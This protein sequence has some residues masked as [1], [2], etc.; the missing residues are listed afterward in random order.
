MVLS[1]SLQVL[2]VILRENFS[3]KFNISNATKLFDKMFHINYDTFIKKEP[4]YLVERISIAVNSLYMFISSSLTNIISSLVII[5][6]SLIIICT[7]RIDLAIF[8]FITVPINYFGYKFLNKELQKRCEVMQNDT[9]TGYKNIIGICKN[10]DYIKQLGSYSDILNIINSSLEKIYSSMANVNRYAQSMSTSLKMFNYL[11]QNITFIWLSINVLI[12]HNNIENIIIVSILLPIFFNALSNLTSANIEIRDLQSSNNFIKNELDQ[13]LENNGTI[14]INKIN[15]IYINLT[16]FILDETQCPLNITG[17]FVKGDIVYVSGVSGSGKS[18]FIKLIPRFRACNN[19]LIDDINLN[20]IDIYSL[21]NRI[22]YVPQ[23]PT[24]FPLSIRE[25]IA[26]GK[27][28]SKINWDS[29]EKN[30]LI[31]PILKGKTLDTI[32]FENGSNLSGGEKQ[33]ISLC[34]E[35][36]NNSDILLLDEI[37]SNIDSESSSDIYK[38]LVENSKDKIIFIISHDKNIRQFCNKQISIIPFNN[39]T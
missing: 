31:Q 34:R 4:T 18:T 22:S 19:I 14:I 7:I 11:V 26:L 28:D 8:F 6:V 12:G 21:R 16:N 3:I 35:L 32:V 37:T 23:E 1:Y 9:S 15:K 33:R 5:T 29:I 25:N 20:E 27:S 39:C 36:L 30:G 2:L 24:I 17:E 13:C 10:V 38:S